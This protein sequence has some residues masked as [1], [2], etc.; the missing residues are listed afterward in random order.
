MK[1]ELAMAVLL[2]AAAGC[3]TAPTN[4]FFADKF[5]TP[6]EIPPFE[7]FTINDY[8]E[9]LLKGLEAEKAD[10]QAII[11]N[12]EAPSFENVIVAMDES[13]RLLSTV[14]GVFGTLSS[15]DSDE[16]MRNLEKEIDP[17]M[18]AHSN[19]IY[20]NDALFAKVKQVYDNQASMNLN[21]EQAKLLDNV[22]RRFVKNGALLSEK[23]KETLRD[24][25]NQLSAAQ[26]E[27]S[28]NLLH[29]TNET[30][31][32]VDS[33]DELPGLPEANVQQAA[34]LAKRIGQEGKFAFNM[35]RPSCNPVLQYCSNR[36]LRKKV[37]DAYNN[38][39]NQ[40]N[41]YNNKALCTKIVN[42]RI[43]KAHL[44]GY[45]DFASMALEDRMAKNSKNVYDL[46]DQVW[47]PAV[48]AAKAEIEDIKVEMA[49]D[50]ISGEPE[51][52]DYMYYLDKAMA[53]K[54]NIDQ[55]KI[56]EYL[57]I[58]N[59]Q[60]GIFYAA[61]KLYGLTFVERT[62]EYPV[63]NKDTK[64]WDVLDKD[65]KQIAIFYSDYF[66]RAGKGAGAWCG[67]FRG[68]HYENGVRTL[69]IVTNVCNMSLPSADK[70][71]LQTL[72]NVE[73][74][75]HEFGHALHSFLR[76]TH[77]YGTASVERD[78]VELPSQI[79]EHWAFQPEV[80]KV[81]AKHYQTGEIIPQELLAK[82]DAANK[83]GQGFVTTELV[84]AMYTD[85]DLHVLKENVD[86]LD[87]IK[88]EEELMGKRGLPK[89]ILPR[90][91][92]TNFSHTM[93]GGYSAGYYSYMWSEVLD[94]DAFE[95]FEETGAIFTPEVAAKFRKYGL[96][97]G[98]VDD[99]AT[100]Y[101]NF[102]GRDPKV[103]ALL[104]NRGFSK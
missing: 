41:Q 46:L 45:E 79:N 11:D 15:S 90:Y 89:Q 84:A 5:G 75:F 34:D 60:Q 99:G 64:S 92:M 87:V 93:G 97:A 63:Y 9:G 71:A 59:V 44:M 88:Y 61:G 77:Y 68:T 76:N 27:F 73:T 58:N 10:I 55:A 35:Q 74:M 18:T 42:L 72:D 86:N 12:P 25:N 69:P 8:R 4:P 100:M 48:K 28:Q 40:D 103:D 22:Y 98:G 20:L 80:M 57:E 43:S 26:L 23:D 33:R 91:R 3:T 101:R 17:L 1:K 14:E 21:K 70:P 37:Y 95:A 83:Y 94:A 13:G 85:M 7:K 56:S 104:K 36:E 52:W 82:V 51:R 24:L 29:E 66:P 39:G 62:A 53:S 30:Y 49:K 19:D 81:Y 54:F 47:A 6:H 50:G 78:F 67:G 96:S 65:G 38:R 32:I 2:V 31:V 16:A 102:R